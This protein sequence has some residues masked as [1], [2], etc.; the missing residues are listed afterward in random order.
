MSILCDLTTKLL[1]QNITG[2]EGMFHTHRMLAYGTKVVAGTAPG[3]GGETV[4]GVPVFNSVKEA[5]HAKSPNT[6]IIFVPAPYAA[7]AIVEAA[8]NAIK[9]IVC[10]TEGV[11]VN[12]MVKVYAHVRA[13]GCRL[14]GPNCPGVITPGQCKVG[15]MPAY[16]Y[17]SGPTCVGVG[18]DPIIGTSFNEVLLLM[19]ADPETK[20]VTLIG[21]IGGTCEE[22]AAAFIATSMRKPVVAFIA[23]K[24]APPEKRMGHAGAIVSGGQGSAA[25]KIEALEAAGVVVG[26]TPRETAQAVARIWRMSGAVDLNPLVHGSSEGYAY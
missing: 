1:V 9:T 16:V 19:E 4:E 12:D 24:A 25:D 22:E 5:V 8:D 6:S 13:K 26:Q 10:I 20:I 17:R 2:R 23:G 15:I 21:E 7:D 14:I 3:H 11:P 18:G